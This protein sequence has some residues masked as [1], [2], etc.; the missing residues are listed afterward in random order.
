MTEA[1]Q[2]HLNTEITNLNGNWVKK[3]CNYEGDICSKL[4][5]HKQTLRYWDATWEGLN[6]EFKKGRSIWLDLVRYSEILMKINSDASK[7]TISLFFIHNIDTDKKKHRTEIV[8]IIAVDTSKIIE[9]LNLEMGQAKALIALHK[10][11]RENSKKTL[12]AQVSMTVKQ[13]EN[14]ADFVVFKSAIK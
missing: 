7:K 9:K 14:I 8:K 13:I 10:N 3:N 1:L 4:G 2:K 6:I 5:M 11:L 12:N